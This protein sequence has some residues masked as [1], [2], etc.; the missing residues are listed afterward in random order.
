[1]AEM[2]DHFR[3]TGFQILD[4]V[5]IKLAPLAGVDGGISNHHG[6]ENDVLFRK[7]GKKLGGNIRKPD[8]QK[9]QFV[10]MSNFDVRG[11][12]LRRGEEHAHVTVQMRGMN[13]ESY[14]AFD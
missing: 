4:G 3:K 7:N 5:D 1:M 8:G 13:S 6:I 14:G 11:E 9:R 2:H 10:F 12:K